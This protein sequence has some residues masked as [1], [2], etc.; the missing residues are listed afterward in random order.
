MTQFHRNSSQELRLPSTHISRNICA[1]V[2]APDEF[3]FDAFS[4]LSAAQVSKC[5]IVREHVIKLSPIQLRL[6]VGPSLQ[7]LGRT[8]ASLKGLKFNTDFDAVFLG[9]N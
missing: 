6:I 1:V 4:V 7:S 2:E 3:L 5:T 8:H 9:R